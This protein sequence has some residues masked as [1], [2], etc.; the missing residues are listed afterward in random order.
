MYRDANLSTEY[1]IPKG[2]IHIGIGPRDDIAPIETKMVFVP[3]IPYS[4]MSLE[5]FFNFSEFE[6]YH[7]YITMPYETLDAKPYLRYLDYTYSVETPATS[8]LGNISCNFKNFPKKGSSAINATF[9]P[10]SNYPF[11]EPVALGVETTMKNLVSINYPRGSKKT[12]ILTFFGGQGSIWDDEFVQFIGVNNLKMSDYPFQVF[13]QFP[14]ENYLATETFPT[15]TKFYVTEGFRSAGFDL[16]FSYTFPEWRGQ[17]I[18]CSYISPTGETDRNIFT[19]ISGILISVGIT[20]LYNSIKETRELF[21]KDT[22]QVETTNNQKQQSG[23]DD[24]PVVRLICLVDSKFK[25]SWFDMF[26]VAPQLPY[27]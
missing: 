24:Q 14:E 25:F 7:V 1:N 9:I 27:L 3:S 21:E 26:F 23:T 5:V 12:I 20:A 11:V 18:S 2:S 10:D 6:K 13:I 16:N 8:K 4:K 19:F 22:N 15:P 17:S